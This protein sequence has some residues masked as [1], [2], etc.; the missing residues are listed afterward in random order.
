MSPVEPVQRQLEAYNARDLERFI[1]QYT[2]DIRVFR[3][4]SP[5]PVLVGKQIFAKHYADNRFTLPKLHA[6]VVNRMVSGSIVVDH[7][8]ITGLQ[9]G[10]VEAIAVYAVSEGLIHTVWF[11]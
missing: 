8:H 2:E 3:P 11:Y 1:A 4:P 9:E 10:V 7:E 5:E 6:E